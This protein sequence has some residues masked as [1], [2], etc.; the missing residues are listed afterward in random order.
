MEQQ[1]YQW[2]NEYHRHHLGTNQQLELGTNQQIDTNHLHLPAATSQRANNQQQEVVG[3]SK[4]IKQWR[5]ILLLT[6]Q[7][8]APNNH[9][10]L[11]VILKSCIESKNQNIVY[12]CVSMGFVYW[13]ILTLYQSI[14]YASSL[15]V[16][17]KITAHLTITVIQLTYT[18]GYVFVIH[19]F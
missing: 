1:R 5:T 4:D 18:S 13:K 10:P 11:T 8:I 15:T 19:G 3:T 17:V 14:K 12:H 6:S 9:L 2:V 7:Y 16:P